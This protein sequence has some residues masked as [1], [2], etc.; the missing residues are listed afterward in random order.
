MDYENITEFNFTYAI[1]GGA[2]VKDSSG[3]CNWVSFSMLDKKMGK[4]WVNTQLRKQG[5]LTGCWI[6]VS[7]AAPATSHDYC[8]S[9]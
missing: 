1:P 3:N 9:I 7:P 6:D 8:K 2:W 5:Q 4:D